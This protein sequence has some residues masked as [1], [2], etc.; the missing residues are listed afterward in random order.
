MLP[1]VPGYP[2]PG[3]IYSAGRP[4]MLSPVVKDFPARVYVPQNSLNRVSVIDQATFKV[5]GHFPTEREPQHVTPSWDLKTLYVGNDQGNTLTVID[6]A[7]GKKTGTRK[8]D[9]PYNLY[10]TPDGKLAIVV[11][12]RLRRLDFRHAQTMELVERVPVPCRGVDHIDFSADGRY[13]IATCEFSS[14]LVKV[15]TLSRKVVGKLALRD[16]GM[17]QD[18]KISP[19]GSRFYVA[20]MENDGMHVVDGDAFKVID[21]IPTGKGCHGLYTS[22]DSKHMYVSNR[23]EGTISLFEFASQKVVQTWKIPGAASPDMGGVS[24]DGKV[25]WL[26]GRYHAEVYAIDTSDGKLLARIKVGRGPHG[27]CVYPQPGRY[28]VGHTGILR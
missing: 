23:N 14:E 2:E 15:D 11:A 19:D 13:L 20:D 6:P 5:I 22:R 10:F 8:V 26:S 17:P 4:G 27:L 16:G 21:F 1:G 7:T 25:L 12:E 18:I 24:A 9:D 3:D 28:S